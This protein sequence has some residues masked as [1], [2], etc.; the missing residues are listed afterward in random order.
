MKQTATS[1]PFK[2]IIII[3]KDKKSNVVLKILEEPWLPNSGQ[4]GWYV[5]INKKRMLV[6]SQLL[7]DKIS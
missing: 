3:I 2:Y 4:Q 5:N 1:L 6:I 7:L